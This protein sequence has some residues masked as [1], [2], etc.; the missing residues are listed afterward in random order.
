MMS[1]NLNARIPESNVVGF[2]TAEK[3]LTDEEVKALALTIAA[4]ADERKGADITVLKVTEV[5]YLADYFVIVTGF[6]N[7]QVRAISRSIEDRVAEEWQRYPLRTEGQTEGNWI[8][9]DYGDV[10]V[11]IFLPDEREFYNLEAFW[12]HAEPLPFV[13]SAP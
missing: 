4:A 3:S 6:S 5:S 7:V 10:I 9:Q 8:L 1:N 11:H 2:P 12:A 13:P